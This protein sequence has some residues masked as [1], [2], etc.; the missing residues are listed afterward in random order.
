M[1]ERNDPT[2]IGE[3]LKAVF[4]HLE[5]ENDISRE[6]IESRWKELVGEG[7]FQHSKP[8]TLRKKV[9]TV[10]IDSSGW[11]QELSMQKRKLLKGLQRTLG[12]D[13]ISEIH[14]KIGEI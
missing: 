5:D 2:P 11:L 4:R 3:V 9:L 7:A 1:K 10:S 14:F 6:F 13:R 8:M 12:K